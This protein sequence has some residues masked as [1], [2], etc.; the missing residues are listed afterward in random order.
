MKSNEIYEKHNTLSSGND[1]DALHSQKYET[2]GNSSETP[3]D[4][5]IPNDAVE[6]PVMTDENYTKEQFSLSYGNSK[7]NNNDY[8]ENRNQ[9]KKVQNTLNNRYKLNA[10]NYIMELH[11]ALIKDCKDNLIE[12]NTVNVTI[13]RETLSNISFRTNKAIKVTLKN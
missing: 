1:N 9:E 7:I 4:K 13:D 3:I 8:D 6:K 2:E 5:S 11:R 10:H 12:F